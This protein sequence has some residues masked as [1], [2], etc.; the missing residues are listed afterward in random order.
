MPCAVLAL[1]CLA[2]CKRAPVDTV[3][4]TVDTSTPTHAISPFIYGANQTNWQTDHRYLSLGRIGGNRMT[5]YNWENNA[6]NAGGDWHHQNDSFLGGGEVPGEVMR[7]AVA[8]ALAAGKGI[9]VTVPAAGYV[10]ADKKGDGDVNQTPNYLSSRFVKSEPKKPSGFSYPPSLT[11][12]KVYQDEFV[13]W[14]ERTFKNR[15]PNTPIF[16][17]IDNEPD[18]WNGTHVRIWP[19]KP[20]YDQFVK[21]TC[22]YASAI[23]GVAPTA[24]VFGPISYGWYGMLTFQDAPDAKQK[25]DFLDYYLDQMKAAERT[26]GK[27]LLDVFDLHWYTEAQSAGKRITSDDVNAEAQTVRVQSTRGLWDPTYKEP[28]WI[29]QSMGDQPVRFIPRMLEKIE[30]HYP[31][32]KLA[33]TEYN[34]GGAHDISGTLAQADALGIFGAYNVFAANVWGGTDKGS[35]INTGFDLY[36]NYDGKGGHFGEQSLKTSTSD[37]AA[38]AIY[39]SKSASTGK[40]TLVVINRSASASACG[41]KVETRARQARVFRAMGSSAAVKELS[42]EPISGGALHVSLPAMSAT[43]FELGP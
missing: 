39:A 15:G 21:L 35:F 16:Y 28:S 42:P 19:H 38:V 18:L 43:V 4:L 33:I 37:V 22:S 12:G 5:A 9:V 24:K 41:I 30:K 1:L 3:V 31:G 7:K 8:D 2:S 11:D 27:R 36:C 14:L 25:G 29:Q 17:A 34:Y 32:T 40:V 10:A 6:S 20:S 26:Y 23:K 13:W